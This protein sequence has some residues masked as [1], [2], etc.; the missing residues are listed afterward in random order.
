[1]KNNIS[2]RIACFFLFIALSQT[3]FS[4]T[5]WTKDPSNPVLKRDTVIAHLPNDLIAISDP[6]VIKEGAV[7]KM[8]YT[9]GGLNFPPDTLLRSRICYA[10][11][12]D[13]IVW[14]KYEDNPVLDVSY[15]GMWDSLGVETASILIDSTAPAEEKYKM[16]YAGQYFNTYRYEIGYA[17]SADGINWIKYTEPV[18]PVGIST[19][20]DNGF[21]EGPSLVKVDDMYKMWYCGYDAIP[22]GNSTDGK[23]NIGYAYSSDGIN[24][25]KY[26]DNPVLI[27]GAD[28]WDSIYVQDPH[29]IYADGIYQMWYGGG[30]NDVTYN[31]QVGY[32]TSTDGINWTKSTLNPVLKKGESGDWDAI[33][34]SFPS[35]INDNGNYKMWYTGR[36]LDPIPENS[37]NYYWEVGYAAESFIGVQN[38]DINLFSISPNPATNF[39][40]IEISGENTPSE[41]TIYNL[42]GQIVYQV[43]L[44]QNQLH[45]NTDEFN[46]GMYIIECKRENISSSRVFTISR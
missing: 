38:Y 33:L 17:Y 41:I 16:W 43:N 18:L 12:S 19:K 31:Q 6:F 44:I 1:M 9:C 14:D 25:T 22:D 2:T 4:Q 40:N 34:A 28:S 36:N 24:W 37:L 3:L 11:S 46:N 5:S 20:W 23:A 39:I 13:G 42:L 26:S 10:T 29:V 15:S 27:T 35:V 32:A 7:Y 45:I 30:D 8:W 21:L